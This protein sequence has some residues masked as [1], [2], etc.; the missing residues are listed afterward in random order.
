MLKVI[1]ILNLLLA[2][3]C[4][5]RQDTQISQTNK[6]NTIA[7]IHSLLITRKISCH[8]VM[9]FYLKRIYTYNLSIMNSKPPL[10][11]ISQINQD[12]L[13]QADALDAIIAKTNRTQGSLFCIPVIVKDNIDVLSME[14]ASGSYALIGSQPIKNAGLVDKLKQHGAII[15]AKSAMDELAMGASGFSSLDGRIGNAYDTTQNPGGS[16]GGS[17]VAVAAGF[18]VIGI[19]T[20]NSGSVRIPAAFNGIYG[21]RPSMGLINRDGVFPMGNIDG[22]P[23]PMTR[24]VTDLAI[25]LNAISQDANT[26]Y[27]K[28]LNP[29]G[30]SGKTIAVL[31]SAGDYDVWLNMPNDIRNIY[32]QAIRNLKK[33]G[34]NIRQLNLNK[35]NNDRKTHMAGT[36]DDVN[37]YLLHNLATRNSMQDMCKSDRMR[38][39]GD[40]EK[41]LKFVNS[42][43]G[44][45]SAK[46]REALAIINNNQKYVIKI[47]RNEHIDG[48]LLPISKTGSSTYDLKQVNTWQA[49]ISSN[50]ALPSIVIQ[51]GHDKNDMP[52]AMEIVG[53][54]FAES[55]LIA[56]AYAYEQNYLSFTPPNLQANNDFGHW[57]ISR[58]NILFR[59]IGK[60]TYQMCIKPQGNNEITP[61]ESYN[62]TIQAI[63]DIS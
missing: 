51:I 9:S 20:D 14:T 25:S 6:L 7:E 16:S 1:I 52:V 22:T 55:N 31:G 46:Y 41:C 62:A 5:N 19:G 49:P 47:M 15:I 48:I 23:G 30:L 43:P 29:Q 27:T 57:S 53:D 4:S 58:L 28:S 21:L 12:I 24:T 38:V 63:K 35:F 54:K 3:S 37:Y 32:L 8:D 26:D 44:K 45:N 42:I 11:A 50:T 2:T 60:V 61:E 18:A 34:A 36:V 56:M 10:N 17:A 33:S 13:N 39:M 59:Q 40:M